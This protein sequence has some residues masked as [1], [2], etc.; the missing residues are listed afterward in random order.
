[1]VRFALPFGAFTRLGQ[2]IH[3]EDILM[4]FDKIWMILS[5]DL[6]TAF[7]VVP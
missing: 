4:L 6:F 3:K 7:F 2:D 5:R 1:M